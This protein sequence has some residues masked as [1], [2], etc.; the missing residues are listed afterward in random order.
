M[1]DTIKARRAEL[2]KA[3]A[4]LVEQHAQVS[5]NLER[6]RGAIGLCD[7]LLAAVEAPGAPAPEET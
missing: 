1:V 3:H 6:V 7:E 5:I 2:V 4:E